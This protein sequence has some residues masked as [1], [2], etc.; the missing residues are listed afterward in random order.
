MFLDLEWRSS[1]ENLKM[2][3]RET[4]SIVWPAMRTADDVLAI[5]AVHARVIR[6]ISAE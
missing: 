4:G 2:G 5:D 6:L 1:F 3:G